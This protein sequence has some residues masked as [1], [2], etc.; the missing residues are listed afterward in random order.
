MSNK[1]Y[2]LYLVMSSSCQHCVKLKTFLPK[3]ESAISQLGNVSFEK[4]ELANMGDKLPSQYPSSLSLF[5]KWYPTFL[6]ASSSEI[7]KSKISGLPIKAT[8]FNG[9]FLENKLTYKNEYPMTDTGI[10]EWCQREMSKGLTK[11]KI[12]NEN[13]SLIPTTVCSKKYKP[14]SNV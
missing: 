11:K 7:N 14:R 12:F 1:D 4:I 3:I 13:E 6:L 2:V 8:V 10:V 9:D 5:I